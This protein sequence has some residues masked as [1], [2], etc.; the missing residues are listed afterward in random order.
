[1]RSPESSDLPALR[2][3]LPSPPS[4][5]S[6]PALPCNSSFPSL[7][8]SVS[9]PPIPYRVSLP[10]PP[11]SESLPLYCHL[12][13]PMRVSFLPPPTSVSF[14]SPPSAQLRMPAIPDP[15]LFSK[16]SLPALPKKLTTLNRGVDRSASQASNRTVPIVVARPPPH[17]V[18]TTISSSACVTVPA[19]SYS[20]VAPSEPLD[21]VIFKTSPD[22]TT[23]GN[24]Q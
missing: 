15:V 12:T 19:S 10:T 20:I 4:N 14:P 1:M 18:D 17:R 3:S 6:Y 9:S 7:P 13:S 11:S 24:V 2:R 5:V 16:A 23:V 21:P 8:N 22:G